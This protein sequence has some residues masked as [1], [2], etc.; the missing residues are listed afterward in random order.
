MLLEKSTGIYTGSIYMDK[1]LF[2][3][4]FV[5]ERTVPR[6]GQ[7]LFQKSHVMEERR[8][9]NPKGFLFLV[10]NPFQAAVAEWKRRHGQSHTSIAN[11]RIFKGKEW[12]QTG[13]NMLLNWKKLAEESIE[14]HNLQGRVILPCNSSTMNCESPPVHLFY[15]EDLKKDAAREMEKILDFIEEEKYFIVPDRA[16]RIKCLQQ[17]NNR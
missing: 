15:Y 6:N 1:R 4:G 7:T 9:P 16:K 17:V 12:I 3:G 2:E 11:E 14:R 10:R 5:G 8:I 13:K